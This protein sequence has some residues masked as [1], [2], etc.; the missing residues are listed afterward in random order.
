MTRK[1]VFWFWGAMDAIYLVRYSVTSAMAGRVPYLGD[2][3]SALWML[4]EHSVVQLYVFG[5]AM[6]LQI[7]LVMSCLLLFLD[8]EWV[9]WVVYLQ[10]PLRLAFVIPSVSLLLVG[11]QIFPSY[12]LVLMAG[13]VIVSEGIKVWSVWRWGKKAD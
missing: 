10:T 3:E 2:I 5:F 4:G 6:L 1:H 11:A 13:F 7:S 8:R 12:N 9:K